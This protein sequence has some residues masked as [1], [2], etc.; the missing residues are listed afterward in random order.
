MWAHAMAAAIGP[1][2]T[3][4]VQRM[5]EHNVWLK[6]L[7]A[8]KWQILNPVGV[9]VVS[10]PK[11]GRTWL[12][13]L[14]GKALCELT[15]QPE[16][17]AL[18]T[19]ALSVAAGI[20]RVM[21]THDAAAM[22]LRGSYRD[23]KPD[24][25]RYR[26]SKV[27]LLGRDVRDTLVSA[28]FQATKRIRVFDQSLSDFVRSEQFGAIKV[29]AFYRAWHELQHEPRAFLFIR[30]EQLHRHPEETLRRALSFIGL[31]SVDDEIIRA[32]VDFA[33]FDN[34]R[35]AEAEGR[36]RTKVLLPRDAD[37]SESYKVRKGKIGNYAQYLNAGDIGYIDELVSR[38]GCDFTA[39][40]EPS[41]R[42]QTV[43]SD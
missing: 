24:R 9:Y 28:Y 20:P 13:A 25:F 4:M 39:N 43:E 27:I 26:K 12:R 18:D 34:L 32:S 17:M 3:V 1:T 2:R 31:P 5:L 33:S 22:I 40:D 8:W 19:E 30:Y 38:L 42:L 7:R 35:K 14:M 16:S 37:D 10:Y 21:F 41:E 23:L 15:H 11:T 36:F 6:T 29:L